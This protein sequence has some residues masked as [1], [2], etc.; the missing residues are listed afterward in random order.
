MLVAFVQHSRITS[1]EAH[2]SVTD[3][4]MG[5]IWADPIGWTSVN[6]A[7]PGACS[8]PPCGSYGLNVDVNPASPTYRQINGFAWNDSAGWICF[9][10]TC[11]AFP[12]VCGSVPPAG[13]MKATIDPVGA[14]APVTVEVRGWANVCNLKDKGWIS[15]NCAD[16]LGGCP[17]YPYRVKFIPAT[18]YFGNPAPPPDV[19]SYAWN[20]NSDLTGYG[21]LDFR[22]VRLNNPENDAIRCAN[23]FDDNVNGKIDCAETSCAAFCPSF[24][25]TPILCSDHID[26]DGNGKVDCADSACQS[27]VVCAETPT[28][29]NQ[30][31]TGRN[32][33][34]DGLDN[35]GN[36]LVDC[37]DLMCGTYAGCLPET[38]TK[39]Y[40]ITLTASSCGGTGCGVGG[41]GG[42]GGTITLSTCQDG[43][44][45]NA[46]GGTDC[47][48]PGCSASPVCA[49]AATPGDVAGIDPIP[50]NIA[51]LNYLCSD[52]FDNG[53]T[54]GKV[55]CAD[56]SCLAKAPI[57]SPIWLQVKYGNIYAQQGIKG[58]SATTSKATYC[59]VSNGLIAGFVSQ[60]GCTEP[61]TGSLTL[62]TSGTGY[63]GTL[64]SLDINGILRGQYGPVVTIASGAP[65]PDVLAGK[66]YRVAG[67]A[68]LG[69]TIF[70][71]SSGNTRGNGLL[72]VDGGNLTITGNLEYLATETLPT[73]IRNLASFGVI[74]RKNPLTGAG[75]DVFINPTVSK[76][77]GA[78]FVEGTI[79]TGTSGGAD[80][81][82]LD[83]FGLIAAHK[84]N[85]QRTYRSTTNA[86]ET[87]IFDGR[88]VAHPPPGMQEVGKSLPASKDA[89]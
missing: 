65:L 52:G 15:L 66:V 60:S 80:P 11:S 4:L 71:N 31:P 40:M 9:G 62:P 14:P 17:A 23:G 72:F 89:F 12:L 21:Y 84:F 19:E 18:G 13:A 1:R 42:G 8:T 50:A 83:I 47:A 26:N 61:T 35:N 68:T 51:L 58:E 28:N 77:S 2:A 78:Y 87:F 54:D 39:S 3:N 49:V 25:N 34:A 44:D 37:A 85:L 73:S 10:S 74:V 16:V 75:G 46:G 56:A 76:I 32:V 70:K 6:S 45:N 7:N 27:L 5:W 69:A 64:G 53:K 33:C 88:A 22:N 59:L 82:R 36:A 57:C 38:S 55:D 43:L 41:G 79:H 30:N 48:D 20:G 86:A 24:E 67:N 81:T 63:K 29:T